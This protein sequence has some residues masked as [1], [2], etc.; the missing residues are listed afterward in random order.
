MLLHKAVQYIFY[1]YII[2]CLKVIRYV[3][4]AGNNMTFGLIDTIVHINACTDVHANWLS[5]HGGNNQ[6]NFLE[7]H[8][9]N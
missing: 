5:E 2:N 9:F 1:I 7:F 6:Q 8:T 3:N 4:C